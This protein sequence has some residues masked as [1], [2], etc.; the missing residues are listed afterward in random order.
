MCIE[1]LRVTVLI[2]CVCYKST[3]AKKILYR[4]MDIP[5]GLMLKSEDFQLIDSLKPLLSK[6]SMLFTHLWLFG[7]YSP[8]GVA[9]ACVP[10]RSTHGP[11]VVPDQ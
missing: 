1:N 8:C 6:V 7:F 2:L 10:T 11:H 3:A 5:T 4:L 9:H